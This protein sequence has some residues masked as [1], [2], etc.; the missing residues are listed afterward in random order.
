MAAGAGAAGEVDV[1][2]GVDG[3]AVILVLDVGV[4]DG[5]TSGGADIEGIGV[6]ATVGDITGAVVDGDV[7]KG[8][9]RSGVNG[10]TL[11]GGVLHVKVGDGGRLERVGVEEL[12]LGLAAVGALA[13]PPLSAVAI[14]DM[15][16]GALDGD[17]GTGDRDE[18]ALPLLVAEAGG[19]LEGDGG[20]VLELG[21]VEGLASRHGDVVQDDVGAR[22]LGLGDRSGILEGAAGT[23]FELSRSSSYKGAS[24]EKHSVKVSGNHCARKCLF[25]KR[26]WV[27]KKVLEEEVVKSDCDA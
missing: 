1:L 6:V 27:E 18:G 19:S 22:S 9:I 11:D 2:A 10:E 13:V 14:N 16:A 25:E 17:L 20:S 26:M 23:G 24:A 3:K 15:A 5:D 12:G 7:V 8:D 4:G 21:Q